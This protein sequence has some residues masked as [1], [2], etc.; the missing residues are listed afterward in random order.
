M[1]EEVPAARLATNEGWHVFEHVKQDLA[2]MIH[3]RLFANPVQYRH[4]NKEVRLA[5][6]GYPFRLRKSS[7]L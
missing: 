1:R 3:H 4:I 5:A 2:V 7:R 6:K